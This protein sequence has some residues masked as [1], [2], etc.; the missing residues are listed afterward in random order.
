MKYLCRYVHLIAISNGRWV[1]LDS[2]TTEKFLW[3]HFFRQKFQ[4]LTFQ[5]IRYD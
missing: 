2:K 3:N 5:F 4:K 1:S